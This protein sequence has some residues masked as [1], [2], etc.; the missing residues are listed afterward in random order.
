[1]SKSFRYLFIVLMLAVR[2]SEGGILLG[3]SDTEFE[4]VNRFWGIT[5]HVAVINALFAGH[6]VQEATHPLAFGMVVSHG[7]MA[8]LARWCFVFLVG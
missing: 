2:L 7:A 4:A 1:M 5:R 8:S 6:L 3:H